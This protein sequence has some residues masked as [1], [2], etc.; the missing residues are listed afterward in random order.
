MG[1][2]MTE[3]I[4]RKVERFIDHMDRI[5]LAGLMSREDYDKGMRE[6]RVWAEQK[7]R[8]SSPAGPE[9]PFPRKNRKSS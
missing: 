1:A 2:N 6:I 5:L 4:E 3:Q 7:A 9:L 8:R